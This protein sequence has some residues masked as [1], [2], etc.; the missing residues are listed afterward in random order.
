MIKPMEW[1]NYHHL[2]YFWTIAREGSVTR[3]GEVLHL[4]QP[5]L[6]AQMRTLERSLG[7]RLFVKVGRGLQLTDTGQLVYR[8]AQEIFGLGQEMLE[9]LQG[10]PAGKQLRFTVGISDALSK[11]MIHRLL[12]PALTVPEPLKLV[13][14]EDKT[15]RLM[16]DLVTHQLDLVLVD[17]PMKP[18]AR[19]KAYNH[20]LATYGVSFFATARLARKHPAP[21]P[22]CLNGAPLLLPSEGAT[23]RRRLDGWIA[24]LGLHPRLEGEF[25]DSALMKSFGQAGVGFF[26][27]PQVISQELQRQYQVREVGVATGIQEQIYAISLERTIKHPAVRAMSQAAKHRAPAGER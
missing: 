24:S 1:L 2:L 6:S 14:R 8:Y 22:A 10:R 15:A 13:C 18:P 3:A 4:S 25:D 26:A 5:T 23:L 16:A 7:E 21:F 17:S 11:L 19:I 12:E 9:T 27:A 20:L